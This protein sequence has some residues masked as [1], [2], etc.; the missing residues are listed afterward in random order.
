MGVGGSGGLNP[1]LPLEKCWGF[2]NEPKSKDTDVKV[3]H[4]TLD[5]A[6]HGHV[7]PPI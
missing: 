7:T 4:P 6:C 5:R 1:T 3:G 2:D